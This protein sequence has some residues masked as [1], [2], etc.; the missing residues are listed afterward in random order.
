MNKNT[1]KLIWA[2]PLLAVFAV[3]AALTLFAAQPPDPALAHDAPGVVKNLTGSADGVA[4]IDLT[5]D[6][7]AA[8][9]G[10]PG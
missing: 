4:A 2:A 9:D 6:A 7:P 5:W 10:G 3:A 8:D 1:R